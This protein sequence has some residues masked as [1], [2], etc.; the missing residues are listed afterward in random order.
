[1]RLALLPLVLGPLAACGPDPLPTTGT[2]TESDFR[3]EL[4]EDDYLLRLRTPPDHDATRPTVLV[5]QLDPTFAGLE[6]FAITSGLVSSRGPSGAWPEAIVL[7]V[8]YPDPGTRL[9]DYTP[10]DPPSE[11]FS[12]PGADTFFAVLRDE[13]LPHVEADLAVSARVIVGHSNGGVFAMYTA[14][15]TEPAV[16]P[17]FAGVVAADF[18]LDAP[19]FVLEERLAAGA[20]DVPIALYASRAVYNGA[21]QQV[22]HEAFFERL[23]DRAYP[24]LALQTAVLDTDHGGAVAPSFEAGLDHVFT[25]LAEGTP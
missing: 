23:S 10:A 24:S 18:G 3:S 17:L 21:V 16:E 13:I 1:M 20:D 15:R 22:A 25:H 14:L 19:M 6:Q 8:D 9:R 5:V 4:V 2:V 11:D 7:G 12:D